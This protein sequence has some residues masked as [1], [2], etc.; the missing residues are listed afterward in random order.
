MTPSHFLS[1][2]S[3]LLVTLSLAACGGGGSSG[4]SSGNAGGGGSAASIASASKFTFPG[5]SPDLGSLSATNDGVYVRLYDNAGPTDVI[6]KR[7]LGRGTPAG[8]LQMSLPV[9]GTFA[10]IVTD[11]EGVDEFGIHWNG[12]APGTG[13]NRYGTSYMNNGGVA[14]NYLD[15]RTVDRI[16][17]DGDA[18]TTGR[19]WGIRAGQIY[20]KSASGSL[21]TSFS[22]RFTR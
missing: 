14:T 2:A 6:A 16:V 3:A 9:T 7:T 10:P 1:S 18:T 21:S 22:A 20:R 12:I 4:G 8:W 15:D 11:N 17:P 5:G 13:T 19:E